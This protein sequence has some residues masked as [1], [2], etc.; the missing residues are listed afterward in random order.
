MRDLGIFFLANIS[1][2]DRNCSFARA[3]LSLIWHTKVI[4]ALQTF[5]TKSS[6]CMKYITYA[7]IWNDI[8]MLL[9]KLVLRQRL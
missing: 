8:I 9:D 1:P 3:N 7:K 5:L 2:D 6:S 4:R